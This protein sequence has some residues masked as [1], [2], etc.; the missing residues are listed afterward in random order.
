M[1]AIA[2]PLPAA[3]GDTPMRRPVMPAPDEI[4]I[5]RPKPRSHMPLMTAVSSAGRRT[6]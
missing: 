2:P 4:V 3:Y 6:G 1:N 5:T